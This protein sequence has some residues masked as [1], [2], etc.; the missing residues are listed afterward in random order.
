MG[1]KWP[2]G[3]GAD[4]L[5]YCHSPEKTGNS[6]AW[7]RG[8]GVEGKGLRPV[9]AGSAGLGRGFIEGQVTQGTQVSDGEGKDLPH[10][11]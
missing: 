9:E 4:Q 3:W 8:I 11:I 7:G 6:L 1:G 5:D 2:L 10:K